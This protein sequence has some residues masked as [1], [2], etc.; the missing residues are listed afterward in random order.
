MSRRI[1]S[2]RNQFCRYQK[3][4]DVDRFFIICLFV[5]VVCV[6]CCRKNRTEYKLLKEID[7]TKYQGGKVVM[8]MLAVSKCKAGLLNPY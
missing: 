7:S 6:Q 1:W 5:F 4:S 3:D 8:A 2:V